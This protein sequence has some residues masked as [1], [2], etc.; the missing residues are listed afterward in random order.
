MVADVAGPAFVHFMREFIGSLPL[1]T[2]RPL[3]HHAAILP[4]EYESPEA[5]FVTPL[6]QHTWAPA[7]GSQINAAADAVLRQGIRPPSGRVDGHLTAHLS[8]HRKRRRASGQ[9]SI[10]L[11]DGCVPLAKSRGGLCETTQGRSLPP[12]P[13]YSPLPF[14]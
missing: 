4:P 12:L 5:S 9:S 6:P 8:T 10:I 3:T 7:T 14:D 11:H 13:R 1:R 2:D